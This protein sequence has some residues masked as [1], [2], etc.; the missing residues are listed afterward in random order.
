MAATPVSTSLPA[1]LTQLSESHKQPPHISNGPD[2]FVYVCDCSDKEGGYSAPCIPSLKCKLLNNASSS[3][4]NTQQNKVIEI[5][6]DSD[7]NSKIHPVTQPRFCKC[8]SLKSY[9]S[10]HADGAANPDLNRNNTNIDMDAT[11]KIPHPS[12]SVQV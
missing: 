8:A 3:G 11:P 4:S 1:I 9:L 5:H 2:R 6:T 7:T 12:S 10:S